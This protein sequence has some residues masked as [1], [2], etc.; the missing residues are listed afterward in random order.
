MAMPNEATKPEN[1]KLADGYY[2]VG[3]MRWLGTG[4]FILPLFF[5][6]TL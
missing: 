5:Y 4:F 6:Y 3:L 1:Y 2:A